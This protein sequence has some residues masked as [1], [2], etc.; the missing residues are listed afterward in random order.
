MNCGRLS[1]AIARAGEQVRVCGLRGTN[2]H[3]Q[4]LRELGLMEGRTVRIVA[5]DDSVVCQIGDCRFGLC[6]RLARCVIVEPVAP[7]AH[8]ESA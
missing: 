2:G 7:A 6:R 3:T 8:A 5:S 4:R 1:M